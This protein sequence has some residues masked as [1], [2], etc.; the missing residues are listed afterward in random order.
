MLLGK[1]KAKKTP[2]QRIL[3]NLE[4]RLFEN[5]LQYAMMINKI[6]TNADKLTVKRGNFADQTTAGE[7]LEHCKE[8]IQQCQ[9]VTSL[10]KNLS[11]STLQSKC[12]AIGAMANE[13]ISAQNELIEQV[14]VKQSDSVKITIKNEEVAPNLQNFLFVPK[15]TGQRF[16]YGPKLNSKNILKIGKFT[17]LPFSL[18]SKVLR[19]HENGLKTF[20]YPDETI[21]D[22]ISTQYPLNKSIRGNK[23]F[24]NL[25]RQATMWHLGTTQ[26]CAS[27]PQL[28]K[29]YGLYYVG[30]FNA[31]GKYHGKGLMIYGGGKGYYQGEFRDGKKHGYGRNV[32]EYGNGS[33]KEGLFLK[34]KII[35]QIQNS[36]EVD[37]EVVGE[38]SG[39][40]SD[41]GVDGYHL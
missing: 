7:V 5:Y 21:S 9:L 18:D 2:Q 35:D 39:Q 12:D 13:A 8:I 25:M 1:R 6:H 10:V 31:K 38:E 27:K 15:L 41:D 40:S 11:S 26:N 19:I 17:D 29:V 37:N 33:V 23:C 3:S 28:Y 22:Y 14:V 24:R 20:K 34:G 4:P 16:K 32:Y 30:E 36:D